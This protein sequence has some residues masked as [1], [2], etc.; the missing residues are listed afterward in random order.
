MKPRSKDTYRECKH[1]DKGI[2]SLEAKIAEDS[3][4]VSRLM[5]YQLT[6]VDRGKRA[7]EDDRSD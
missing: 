4:R 1:T 5:S 2:S 3:V 6:E 7:S